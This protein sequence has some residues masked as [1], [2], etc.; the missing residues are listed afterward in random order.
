MFM[1]IQM[2]YQKNYNLNTNRNNNNNNNEM[3]TIKMFNVIRKLNLV[4]NLLAASNKNAE[5]FGAS[6][7]S[8][9]S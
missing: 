2:T 7:W 6:R 9:H 1:G 5:L 4:W 3:T 8:E